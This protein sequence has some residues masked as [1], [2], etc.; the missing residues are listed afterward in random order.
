M[1]FS[2]IDVELATVIVLL[3]GIAVAGRENRRKLM[4]AERRLDRA[5]TMLQEEK[6]HDETENR[7]RKDD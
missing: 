7:G 6:S 2:E 3:D 4:E 5:K 1:E